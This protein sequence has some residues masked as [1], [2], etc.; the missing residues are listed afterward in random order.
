MYAC[1]YVCMRMYVYVHMYVYIYTYTY[2]FYLLS[3]TSCLQQD[4][5][6]IISGFR[7]ACLSVTKVCMQQDCR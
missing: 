4:C 5:R 1:M 2:M 3:L 6:W 7:S